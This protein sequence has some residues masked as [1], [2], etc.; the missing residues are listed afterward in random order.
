MK[1]V[2]YSAKAASRHGY[3]YYKLDSGKIVIGTAMYSSE[4]RANEN[5]LWEDK[6]LMGQGEWFA[7]GETGSYSS[8]EEL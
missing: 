6:Q 4:Q 5:Y 2:Y 3:S 7:K 8:K 1:F